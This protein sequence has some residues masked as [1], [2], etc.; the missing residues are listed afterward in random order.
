MNEKRKKEIGKKKAGEWQMKGQRCLA[1]PLTPAL[2]ISSW[3]SNH[4]GSFGPRVE[5]TKKETSY[6]NW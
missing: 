5:D 3:R 2:P 1:F 6:V 4:Q